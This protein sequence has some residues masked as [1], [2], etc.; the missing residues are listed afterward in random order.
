MLW[1]LNHKFFT[2]QKIKKR[3]NKLNIKRKERTKK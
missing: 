3:D 1:K 2:K